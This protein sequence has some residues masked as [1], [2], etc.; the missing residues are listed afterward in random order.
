MVPLYDVFWVYR[1]S[2]MR[3][4]IDREGRFMNHGDFYFHL[5]FHECQPGYCGVDFFVLLILYAV[6][7]NHKS[8]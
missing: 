2:A 4:L 5:R 1:L 8:V 3:Q 7:R 6:V